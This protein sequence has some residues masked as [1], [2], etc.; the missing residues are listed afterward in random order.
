MLPNKEFIEVFLYYDKFVGIDIQT[1]IGE[2]DFFA[3]K[4]K[5]IPYTNIQNY[6]CTNERNLF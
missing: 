5:T 4:I 3:L 1:V 2:I 6:S